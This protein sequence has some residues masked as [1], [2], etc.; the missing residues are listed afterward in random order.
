MNVDTLAIS[1]KKHDTSASYD[2]LSQG[3]NI[4]NSC[5]MVFGSEA[6]YRN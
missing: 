1:N 2:F 4:L 3:K 5:M 6:W